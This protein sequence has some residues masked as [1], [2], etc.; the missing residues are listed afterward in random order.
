V[1]DAQFR[2]KF[3]ELIN[4]RD[5]SYHPLVWINGE[6]EIGP[7]TYVGGFSEINA[8]GARVVIGSNCDIA[9]FVSINAADSHRKA[10]GLDDEV[11]RKDIYIGDHVFIGTHSAVLG[12]A[13]VGER[14]VIGAGTIVRAGEIPP[15]SLVVGIVKPYH[16]RAAYLKKASR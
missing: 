9:S 7:G 6:P 10:I 1:D 2:Q 11:E 5:N 13:R 3:L 15:F 16:F 12:G 4:N 8:K 14:S